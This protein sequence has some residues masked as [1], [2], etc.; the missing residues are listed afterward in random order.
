MSWTWSAW[1]GGD[2]W[3]GHSDQWSEDQWNGEASAHWRWD[4][5]EG[6]RWSWNEAEGGDWSWNDM[7]G[8]RWGPIVMTSE[9]Q[10]A[11][12]VWSPGVTRTPFFGEGAKADSSSCV[13]SFAFCGKS[14]KFT[15]LYEERPATNIVSTNAGDSRL[16]L[17]GLTINEAFCK[18]L[19]VLNGKW[20]S[21]GNGYQALHEFMLEQAWESPGKMVAMAGLLEPLAKASLSACCARVSGASKMK[22]DPLGVTFVDIFHND[23]RPFNQKNVG[24]LYVVGPNGCEWMPRCIKNSEDFLRAVEDMASNA[25]AAVLDYNAMVAADSSAVLPALE[26]VQWCLV[27]GGV[28]CHA[29]C[30]KLDVA[31]ATLRGMEAAAEGRSSSAP[32]TV[33]FAYDEAAFEEAVAAM[34]A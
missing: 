25:I 18:V 32:L 17:G 11:L 30:S 21:E 10:D 4:D 31:Q 23:A 26:T 12:K 3:S 9:L 34:K 14:E 20:D 19:G 27:S 15:P 2:Q 7:E 29:D 13:L 33:R 1:S 5:K 6:G 28:Y 16:Y 24:M 8:D 22:G